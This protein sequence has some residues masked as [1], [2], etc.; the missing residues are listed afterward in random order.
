[1]DQTAASQFLILLPPNIQAHDIPK[2]GGAHTH[3][4]HSH[5]THT[6][7]NEMFPLPLADSLLSLSEPAYRPA[8]KQGCVD[9]CCSPGSFV[10]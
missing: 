1:M 4:H 6:L 2:F 8:V 7:Q 9:A 10:V 3:T 5:A